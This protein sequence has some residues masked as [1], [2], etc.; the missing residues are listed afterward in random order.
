[1]DTTKLF[2]CSNLCSCHT[3]NWL[4]YN[5]LVV[6]CRFHVHTLSWAYHSS[7]SYEFR[8]RNILRRWFLT[9]DLIIRVFFFLQSNLFWINPLIRQA[10]SCSKQS[11]LSITRKFVKQWLC[12]GTVEYFF[13]LVCL[14]SLC[15]S[16][17]AL[18]VCPKSTDLFSRALTWAFSSPFPHCS[19][20][21]NLTFPKTLIVIHAH[22][23]LLLPLTKS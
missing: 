3:C 13:P 17:P 19:S 22:V 14:F 11:G 12:T 2:M 23:F 10:I 6:S 16:W 9:Y 5:I 8:N 18:P 1:M 7:L 21:E 4:L 20:L 15:V